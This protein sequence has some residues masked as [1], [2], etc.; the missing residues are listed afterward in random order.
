MESVRIANP[1]APQGAQTAR[2]KPAPADAQGAMG[3][4]SFL[5]LL[6]ALG[7]EM[8]QDLSAPAMTL[9]DSAVPSAQNGLAL[10][11]S[12]PPATD[13][14]ALLA[15]QGGLASA[16]FS[17]AAL[18]DA[19]PPK[20]TLPGMGLPGTTAAAALGAGVGP[21]AAALGT[22]PP[23]PVWN[24]AA[25]SAGM[26]GVLGAGGMGELG[27]VA[28]TAALDAAGQDVAAPVAGL[29]VPGARRA[30]ARGLGGAA[31]AGDLGMSASTLRGTASERQ[32]LA[33][34]AVSTWQ[35]LAQTSASTPLPTASLQ[36][37]RRES[38]AGAVPAWQAQ[39]DMAS[40]VSGQT[41]QGAADWLRGGQALARGGDGTAPVGGGYGQGATHEPT[42]L[43]DSADIG[44][45][46]DPS[47]A[48]GPE[49]AV[50]EQVAYWV[51][52]NIQNAELT[53]E[54]AGR[55]V[56][57]T[58][59]LQGKEAHVTFRSDE[60]QTRDLIDAN[61]DQ[62]RELLGREGLELSG[63]TVGQSGGQSGQSGEENAQRDGQ[64]RGARQASVQVPS[65]AANGGRP[66]VLTDRSVDVFV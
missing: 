40:V 19:A 42:A 44:Q 25:S 57:V 17:G 16:P 13:M 29:P 18:P 47:A 53:I 41:A 12:E 22:L 2:A 43:T 39:A 50:A 31:S 59:S 45:P 51:N 36:A 54:H 24:A 48:L 65:V 23:Q 3:G 30:S 28:Q 10:L 5:S 62:L 6:S 61:I 38:A 63:V 15:L 52:Q 21:Q 37:E 8:L 4:G 60:G 7:G 49:D 9:S 32:V 55:P 64:Q 35:T 14:A 56:E 20:A 58:V 27:L 66:S 46:F 1:Q 33:S 34:G 26:G 11:A